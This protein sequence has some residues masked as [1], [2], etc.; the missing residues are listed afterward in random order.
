MRNRT[1]R[2]GGFQAPDPPS[3]TSWQAAKMVVQGVRE[4]MFC[5]V[6][7]IRMLKIASKCSVDLI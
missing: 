4:P 6:A 2:A 7:P 5:H 1:S 3:G